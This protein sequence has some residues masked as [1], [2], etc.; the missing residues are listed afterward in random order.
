MLLTLLATGCRCNT[1]A[2]LCSLTTQPFHV[3]LAPCQALL[4]TLQ[5]PTEQHSTALLASGSK[6]AQS[7]CRTSV[8][9][10]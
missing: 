1:G 2:Q 3:R 7:S 5:N 4:P 8:L 10:P 9:A 6:I